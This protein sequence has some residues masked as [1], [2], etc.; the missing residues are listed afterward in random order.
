MD[1]T[2]KISAGDYIAMIEDA[3]STMPGDPWRY[4]YDELR[5]MLADTRRQIEAMGEVSHCLS[6]SPKPRHA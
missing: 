2:P 1:I 6:G 5:E 3:I 4:S